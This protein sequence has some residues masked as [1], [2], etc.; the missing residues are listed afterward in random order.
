MGEKGLP[1]SEKETLTRTS[2]ASLFVGRGYSKGNR[3]ERRSGE[4]YV[5]SF[6]YFTDLQRHRSQRF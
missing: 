4:A 1:A 6:V 2:C 5:F 3:G